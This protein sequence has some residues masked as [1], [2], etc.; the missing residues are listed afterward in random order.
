V[1]YRSPLVFFSV[2]LIAPAGG[3]LLYCKLQELADSYPKL[4]H[5]SSRPALSQ[6]GGKMMLARIG[7]LHKAR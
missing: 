5:A 1:L 6:S 2:R 4:R 7:W 3:G